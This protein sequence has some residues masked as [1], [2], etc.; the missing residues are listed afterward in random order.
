MSLHFFN[1]KRG[2][3]ASSTS[4]SEEGGG[5]PPPP[6]D[7]Y[8]THVLT[9]DPLLYAPLNDTSGGA[10]VDL[11]TNA[12]VGAGT[13]SLATANSV[14]GPNGRTAQKTVGSYGSIWFEGAALSET[15]VTLEWWA[16]TT[17]SNVGW[18]GYSWGPGQSESLQMAI[19]L[20]YT[21]N[22]AGWITWSQY[23]TY[24]WRSTDN[25]GVN[26]GDWH[27]Y[28]MSQGTYP[29]PTF[30]DGVAVSPVAAGGHPPTVMDSVGVSADPNIEFCC[31]AAYDFGFTLSD[32]QANYE[33]MF[34]N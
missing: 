33:A 9:L 5:T 21:P 31:L 20:N 26:D 10:Y 13:G 34:P 3:L 27:H 18:A 32:A 29:W 7:G 25:V 30:V 16:R 17:S 14:A 4:T 11:S 1:L 12:L 2:S 15:V 6:P 24:S 23:N 8:S 22:G 28:V 19:V